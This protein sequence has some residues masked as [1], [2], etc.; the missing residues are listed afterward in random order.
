MG[1]KIKIKGSSLSRDLDQVE[2]TTEKIEENQNERSKKDEQR[3]H[4]MIRS[5]KH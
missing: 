1:R 2:V 5:E 3:I 4:P